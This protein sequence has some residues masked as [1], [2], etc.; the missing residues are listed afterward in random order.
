MAATVITLQAGQMKRSDQKTVIVYFENSLDPKDKFLA[1]DLAE[2]M[3]ATAGVHIDW[4]V[5]EPSADRIAAEL[6]ILV[7][8]VFDTPASYHPGALAFATPYEGVHV[9]IF[10]D[11]VRRMRDPRATQE[12]LAHVLAHEITHILQ[13]MVRH[14]ESGI[15]KARWT[16]Q[17]YINM[18]WQPL[19][20]TDDDIELI[21]G[22]V[23][24]RMRTAAAPLAGDAMPRADS[25]D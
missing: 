5:G 14:S 24:K 19:S 4:C 22:G 7:R 25:N 10:Y 23:A 20:F 21:Q 18:T 17:D 6:P 11:R 9:K 12:V 16:K 15:M 3:F 2:K 13:G 1:E 8:F